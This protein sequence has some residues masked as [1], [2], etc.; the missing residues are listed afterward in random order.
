MDMTIIFDSPGCYADSVL[1][2]FYVRKALRNLLKLYFADDERAQELILLL[3]GQM[4]DD[5]SEETEAL[6]LLQSRT[7]EGL[8]WILLDGDLM[9]LPD[10]EIE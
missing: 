8:T 10:D 1:G 3:K 5:A 4:S 7:A 9:L 2:H 6:E